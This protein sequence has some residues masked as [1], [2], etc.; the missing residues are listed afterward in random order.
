MTDS[1]PSHRDLALLRAVAAGR[2]QI[3]RSSEP[4]LFIDGLACCDQVAAG[5]LARS[6]LVEPRVPAAPGRRVPARLTAL[7]A[8]V[9]GEGLG[10]SA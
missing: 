5:R 9:L 2:A 3:T 6:G 1:T 4:D 8:R 7:G 10:L